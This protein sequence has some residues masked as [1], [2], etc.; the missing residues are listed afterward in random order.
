MLPEN[1]QKFYPRYEFAHIRRGER[2]ATLLGRHSR[3]FTFRHGGAVVEAVRLAGAFFG[4]GQFSGALRKQP[5]GYRIEQ[6]LQGDYVQPLDAADR[7]ADGDWLAMPHARRRRTN[8]FRL[9]SAV[10]AREIENGFELSIEV[11]GTEP[12]PLAIEITL[13]PG[14]NLT[15]DGLL[16][17]GGAAH[18]FFLKEGHAVYELAGRR[19]RIGPGFRRHGWTQLRGAEPRIDGLT[20]YL[21]DFTPFKRTIQIS[22]A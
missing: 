9:H 6:E 3:F 1:Y 22:A 2:S 18:A 5:G 8:R 16:P 14:G 17:A 21:T 12:V 15:G 7:R 20:L 11:G 10:A 19:L 4:K 13:R